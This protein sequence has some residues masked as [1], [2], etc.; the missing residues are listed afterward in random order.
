MKNYFVYPIGDF[1]ERNGHIYGR[2]RESTVPKTAGTRKNR[3][4]ETNGGN[5]KQFKLYMLFYH[6]FLY[7][8]TQTIKV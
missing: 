6:K 5:T 7:F 8:K 2:R 1:V 3:S 4:A